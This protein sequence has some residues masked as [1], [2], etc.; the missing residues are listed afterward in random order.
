[1]GL[2]KIAL[3]VQDAVGAECACAYDSDLDSSLPK[4]PICRFLPHLVEFWKNPGA[5]GAECAED[6]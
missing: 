6:F 5:D 3:E 4:T 2:E 1:M